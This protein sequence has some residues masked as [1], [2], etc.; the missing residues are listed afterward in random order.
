MAQHLLSYSMRLDER[1]RRFDPRQQARVIEDV[2][3]AHAAPYHL[4][5]AAAGVR[6]L[7]PYDCAAWSLPPRDLEPWAEMLEEWAADPVIWV[8][9]GLPMPERDLWPRPDS[10]PAPD[11]VVYGLRTAAAALR[12]RAIEVARCAQKMALEPVGTPA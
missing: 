5:V 12:H 7:S 2:S 10:S 11:V 9:Q 3:N 8:A 6:R 4:R 1:A